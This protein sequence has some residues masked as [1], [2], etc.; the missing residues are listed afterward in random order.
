MLNLQITLR[1][2]YSDRF[3]SIKS[4]AGSLR[5]PNKFWEVEIIETSD[6]FNVEID[7]T[8]RESHAGIRT[9]FGL[10]GYTAY[11]TIYDSRHWNHLEGRW[12]EEQDY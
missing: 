4:W 5:I 9:R 3:N 1:N 7:L 8:Y 12:E 2:P 10:F 6:I 11:F